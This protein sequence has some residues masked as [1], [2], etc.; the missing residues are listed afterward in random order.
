MSITSLTVIY[1]SRCGPSM[2]LLTK[3]RPLQEKYQINIIDYEEV[4]S[5]K[6]NI[7]VEKVPVLVVNDSDVLIGKKAFDKIDEILNFKP[8]KKG[9]MYENLFIA[10]PDTGEKKK[11]VMPDD[12]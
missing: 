3:I 2:E 1:H 9:V 4:D 8:K 12:K 5:A 7:K 10:P 11:V 6:T